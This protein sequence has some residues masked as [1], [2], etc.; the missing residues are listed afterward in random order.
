MIY[1]DKEKYSNILE[2]SIDYLENRGFENL[3]A[4][5]DGYETPKSYAKKGTDI[6][7]T[8]DIVATKEG[9]K[10]IFDISL[11]SEKPR[12]LK[13]KWLFLNTLS[14]LKSHRFKLI[15]TRGHIQFSKDMLED[16]NLSDKKLIRI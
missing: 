16:I 5:I 13:S 8:P 9:R 12:L 15:T 4:D 10:Y 11:K 3:K 14:T 1:S 7:V 6:A 2:N